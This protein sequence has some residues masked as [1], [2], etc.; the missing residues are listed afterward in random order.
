MVVSQKVE[1]YGRQVE[2]RLRQ[3]GFR[4]SG[5]YRAEK[6]GSKIRDAQL[7]LVPY[8]LVLGG[9]EAEAGQVALRDR[10]EGDLGAMSLEAAITRLQAEVE[11]RT[12][13][14]VVKASA[15]LGGR[16]EGNEY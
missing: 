3:A 2:A 4:V 12:I 9:R 11:A 8:M 14:Q 5:D 7:E 16:Q 15:G 6:I 1:E 13:R 10:L